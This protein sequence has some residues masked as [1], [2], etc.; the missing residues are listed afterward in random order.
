MI[1]VIATIEVVEGRCE[2]FL[3]EFRRVVP[4]V[5]KEPGC[6]AYAP[7]VDVATGIGLQTPARPDVVTVV[8]QWESIEALE[9]HLI[10][11]H[12]IEYRKRVKGLLKATSI[13]ILTPA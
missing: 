13:R 12:M 10:A 5:L 1:C 6:L 8:E 9:D 7:M 4:Q 11:P 3:A 2:D